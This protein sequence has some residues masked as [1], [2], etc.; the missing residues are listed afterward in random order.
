M[1]APEWE[2]SIQDKALR[3]YHLYRPLLP[4]LDFPKAEIRKGID[5][6]NVEDFEPDTKNIYWKKLVDFGGCQWS[7]ARTKEHLIDMLRAIASLER[8]KNVIEA[9]Y[10]LL[11]KLLMPMIVENLVVTKEQLEGE[12]YLDNN[13][14]ALLVEYFSY[15]GEFPLGQIALDFKLSLSQAYRIMAGQNGN[16]QEISKSPTIYRPSKKLLQALKSLGLELKK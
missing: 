13:L 7:R 14:L 10:I 5:I 6:D 9:D 1:L 16:W 11:A 2:S 4:N 3:Y 12:R 15:D 8:R